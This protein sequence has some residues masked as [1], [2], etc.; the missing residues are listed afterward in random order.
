[1]LLSGD[2]LNRLFQRSQTVWEIPDRYFVSS[3]MTG[4]RIVIPACSW[5]GISSKG[6]FSGVRLIGRYRID[7]SYLPV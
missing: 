6:Y 4:L 5:A 3:G 7:T 2:L 1:M